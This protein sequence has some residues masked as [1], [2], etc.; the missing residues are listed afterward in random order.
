M[1]VKTQPSHVSAKPPPG[2]A[3][4]EAS[5]DSDKFLEQMDHELT[6]WGDLPERLERALHQD[7]LLLYAQPIEIAAR[8]RHVSDCRDARTP[9]RGR[10]CDAAAGCFPAGLRAL[11][12]DARARPLGDPSSD[13]GARARLARAEFSIN[14][15]AQTL[16]DAGFSHALAKDLERAGVSPDS[17]V[18]EIDENDLLA[19]P[20]AAARF[21]A[22][23]KAIGCRL[24]FDG[25][26]RR[27]VSFEPLKTLRVDY[28]KVDGVIIRK[29]ASSD[30][31]RSKLNAI[32]RVGEVIGV[33]VIGECVEDDN[34][35][36]LLKTAGVGY[37]QGSASPCRRRSRDSP[38][39]RVDEIVLR[40]QAKWPG[41]PDVYGWLSLDRRGRW[42]LRNPVREI[43]E[44]IGNA[45]LRQFIARN[46]ARDARGRWFFQNGPQRVFVRL[47]YTPL[48]AR[49]EGETFT[50]Q[51]GR[52]LRGR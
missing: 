37:A 25:F 22:A 41:V 6:G 38:P 18:F 32:S 21:S 46:Y 24:L 19:R 23:V 48:V 33:G 13:C 36:A 28:V 10:G 47:A 5:Q 50:D 34:V 3:R 20:D 7:E 16:G 14:I 40:A 15:S 8:A 11:R 52:H 49:A 51:C 42:L 39:P 45:A 9:A 43:Y 30:V 35:I 17:L 27:S 29:L 44:P 1:I 2:P 26:G 31:A 12:N 4:N